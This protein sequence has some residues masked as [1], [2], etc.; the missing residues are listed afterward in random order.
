MGTPTT[1]TTPAPSTRDDWAVQAA[2][3]IDRVVTGL[4]DKTARPLTAVAAAIVYGLVAGAALLA[5]LVLVTV[6]L[7]RAGV[8]YLPIEPHDRVVWVTEAG[9]GGIFTLAGL[10]VWRKRRPKKP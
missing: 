3:T 7:V 9:L 8:S 2:D 1:P 6:A 5:L 4:G 10:F